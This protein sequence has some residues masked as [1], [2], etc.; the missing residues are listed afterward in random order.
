MVLA[1][2][3]RRAAG[4]LPCGQVTSE[5]ADGL[6]ARALLDRA[7]AG[8]VLLVLGSAC[9]AGDPMAVLGP[10]ARACL[11]HAPC[12]VV[13]VSTHPEHAGATHTRAQGVPQSRR[14]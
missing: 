4:L 2:A 5:L 3:A 6:P 7:A 10:V 14:R 11:R 1:S 8:A 12:P 9:P 13:I